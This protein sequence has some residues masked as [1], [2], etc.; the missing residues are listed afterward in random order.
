MPRKAKSIL[1]EA[2]EMAMEYG[3]TDESIASIHAARDA[4]W[5]LQEIGDVLNLTRERVRQLYERDADV[6]VEGFPQKPARPK[7]AKPVPGYVLRRGLVS[8]EEIA[9]LA[10]M[11]KV[12]KRRR[13]GS[14]SQLDA[15]AE[16]FWSRVNH[17]V[18]LGV[19]PSWLGKQMGLSSTTLQAG[20]ARYGYR[21]AS[22]SM[23]QLRT[24][25]QSSRIT[26]P[27]AEESA[28]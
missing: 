19:S 4:G 14:D 5:T 17:L 15:I 13:R 9:E 27:E 7:A 12:A 10:E 2:S 8:A 24:G 28:S 21:K 20:L 22:P 11:Q 3:W 25:E 26:S 1:R 6:V 23:T 18:T 16:E